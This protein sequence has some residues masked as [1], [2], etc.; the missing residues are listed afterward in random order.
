MTVLGS[1]RSSGG[2]ALEHQILTHVRSP[3]SHVTTVI[4]NI[5]ADHWIWWT[6]ISQ[7]TL[8][9]SPGRCWISCTF[10]PPSPSD[11]EKWDHRNPVVAGSRAAVRSISSQIQRCGGEGGDLKLASVAQNP[12]ATV[13]VSSGCGSTKVTKAMTWA[14]NDN[15]QGS[16]ANVLLLHVVTTVTP[17]TMDDCIVLFMFCFQCTL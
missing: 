3:L 17:T 11:G 5:T 10:L 8:S 15:Q 4:S 1:A 12:A 16:G 9:Y 6:T 2:I 13:H 14:A 7:P